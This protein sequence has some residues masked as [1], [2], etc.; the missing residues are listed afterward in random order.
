MRVNNATV[1]AVL[2]VIREIDNPA[3]PARGCG[4]EDLRAATQLRPDAVDGVLEDPWSA[5]RIEGILQVLPRPGPRLGNRR[6]LPVTSTV[7]S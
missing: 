2:A 1:A 5:D 3:G 7:I 6:S 4:N